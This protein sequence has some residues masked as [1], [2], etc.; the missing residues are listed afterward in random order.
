MR[1][2]FEA[3]EAPSAAS[4]FVTGRADTLRKL[5]FLLLLCCVIFAAGGTV[6]AETLNNGGWFVEADGR[7]YFR[8]YGNGALSKAGLDGQFT[9]LNTRYVDSAI[10]YYNRADGTVHEAFKDRGFGPI[11]YNDGWL[12]MVKAGD[13]Y[14]EKMYRVRTDGSQTESLPANKFCAASPDG[15]LIAVVSYSPGEKLF[16]ILYQGT[17]CTAPVSVDLDSDF[18]VIGMDEQAVYYLET[19]RTDGRTAIFRMDKD[20]NIQQLG[21]YLTEP[22]I[23]TVGK[24][25]DVHNGTGT[26]TVQE[27]EGTARTPAGRRIIS[28]NGTSCTVTTQTMEELTSVPQRKW[29]TG[30][31]DMEVRPQG[32]HGTGFAFQHLENIVPGSNEYFAMAARYHEDMQASAGWHTGSALLGMEYLLLSDDGVT[33]LAEI[34]DTEPMTAYAKLSEEGGEYRLVYQLA[35]VN[36]PEAPVHNDSA[37]Y[38]APLAPVV[39]YRTLNFESGTWNELNR[40]DFIAELLKNDLFL[41]SEELGAMRGSAHT[42]VAPLYDDRRPHFAYHLGFNEAGEICAARPV[43]WD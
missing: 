2:S 8:E 27:Y 14:N 36:G 12:Y 7:V 37:S 18:C 32:D 29:D 19:L 25:F 23:E 22:Y 28:F 26:A 31:S 20:G 40:E 1:L 21:S 24:S 43:F 42:G 3:D 39:D 13:T 41:S 4:F 9:T 38:I 34:K 15:S 30:W 10:K 16:T 6:K 33:K 11:V 35:E 5:L 17:A